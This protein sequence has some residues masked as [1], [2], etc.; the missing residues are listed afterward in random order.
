MSKADFIQFI[1]NFLAWAPGFKLTVLIEARVF[2]CFGDRLN[3]AFDFITESDIFAPSFF[4]EFAIDP[5]IK[6]VHEIMIFQVAMKC[7]NCP[8]API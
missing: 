6:R 3:E 8:D 7:P 4:N 2:Y 5:A 1:A